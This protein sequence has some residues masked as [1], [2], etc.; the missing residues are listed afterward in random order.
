MG[1]VGRG[2]P[3]QPGAG[4]QRP[5][6]QDEPGLA[7][8]IPGDTGRGRSVG[9]NLAM[10][11]VVAAGVLVVMSVG[12]LAATRM[13]MAVLMPM[14]FALATMAAAAARLRL[15]RDRARRMRRP[16]RVAEAGDALLDRVAPGAALVEGERQRLRH[17]R[18]AHIG[19]AGQ[20]LDRAADLGRAAGAIHAADRPGQRFG[21]GLGGRGHASSPL[22]GVAGPPTYNL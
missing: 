3:D 5:G 19:D 22:D 21:S 7:G 4:E 16:R 17:H 8:A 11:A 1:G 2:Q 6:R 18:Q 10:S 9:G 20:A 13:V 12:G 15:G 14:R